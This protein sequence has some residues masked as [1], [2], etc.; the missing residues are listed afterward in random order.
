MKKINRRNMNDI[1]EMR[2][3]TV[4]EFFEK[5]IEASGFEI[6]ADRSWC[7]VVNQDGFI[8]STCRKC[9]ILRHANF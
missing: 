3:L 4:K 2:N 8:P 9:R 5:Y 6:F 1:W 7:L